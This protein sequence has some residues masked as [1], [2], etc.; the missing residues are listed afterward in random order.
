MRKVRA[1]ALK[2]KEAQKQDRNTPSKE[3]SNPTAPEQPVAK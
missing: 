1:D 2:I 3:E